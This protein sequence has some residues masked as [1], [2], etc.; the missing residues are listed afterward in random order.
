M[1]ILAMMMVIKVTL[2]SCCNRERRGFAFI[3]QREQAFREG[4]DQSLIQIM[5]ISFLPSSDEKDDIDD[6]SEG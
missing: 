1:M 3:C 5:L 4:G 2:G 6:A